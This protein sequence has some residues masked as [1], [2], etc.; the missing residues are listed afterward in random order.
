MTYLAILLRFRA[1]GLRAVGCN[2]TDCRQVGT[3]EKSLIARSLLV[4]CVAGTS[5]DRLLL[6]AI[7]FYLMKFASVHTICFTVARVS[8]SVAFHFSPLLLSSTNGLLV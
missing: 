2:G 1:V 3:G 8:S 6:F 5:L 4:C 7:S